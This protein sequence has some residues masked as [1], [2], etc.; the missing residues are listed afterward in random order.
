[1]YFDKAAFGYEHYL[2]KTGSPYDA[3]HDG[4]IDAGAPFRFDMLGAAQSGL[5]QFQG[6]NGPMGFPASYEWYPQ[7]TGQDDLVTMKLPDGSEIKMWMRMKAA[8]LPAD[9][10]AAFLAAIENYPS[11]SQV[12]LGGHGVAPKTQ[13]LGANSCL[14]CHGS[15][16]AL[17]HTVPVGRRTA[18]DMGPMGQI[19]LPLYRWRYYRVRALTDLGLSVTSEEIVAGTKDVDIDGDTTYVRDSSAEFIVNWF[20]PEMPGAWRTA[21]DPSALTG[22]GLAAAD[23]TKNGGEWMPVLEPVVDLLPNWA[24]LGYQESELIWGAK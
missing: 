5:R 3:D 12:T 15:S 17:A 18:V 19:E 1:L 8:G 22:T 2:V 16:G 23:L 24:V 6:F 14:D 7:F 4:I 13:A 9:Q 21:D 20:M 10:Q 11:F